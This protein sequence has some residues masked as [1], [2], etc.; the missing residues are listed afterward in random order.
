M[1]F[2][3]SN[4]YTFRNHN[5]GFSLYSAGMASL[6]LFFLLFFN[7]A[8]TF[9]KNTHDFV[10]IISNNSNPYSTTARNIKTTLRKN[11]LSININTITLEEYYSQKESLLKNTDIFI[12]L[13]QRAFKEVLKYSGNTPVFA[14]LI[15]KYDFDRI[16]HNRKHSANNNIGAIYI[17]QPFDRHLLFSKLVLPSINR[18]SFIVNSDNKYIINKLNLLDR[19]SYRIGILNPGDNVIPLLTHLLID[20]DAVIAVPD[21]IIFN[22]RT[23]RNILLGTYRKRVPVI[24]FSESYVKAGALAAIYSTPELIGNQTG[25]VISHLIKKNSLQNKA[26]PLPRVYSKYFSISVNKRV[27]RSLGLPVLNEDSLENDLLEIEKSRHK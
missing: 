3:I 14:S 18:F 9:A 26:I 4:N 6:F 1:M 11:N 15:S 16:I 5:H 7:P 8:I 21:P 25:E 2:P 23:T 13:G 20:A 17:D 10:L 22:L 24:G 27:S 19:D 12:P